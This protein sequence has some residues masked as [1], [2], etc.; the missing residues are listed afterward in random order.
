MACWDS[1][2]GRIVHAPPRPYPGHRGWLLIDCGCCAGI[3]WGGESP[4]ECD[5]CA[6]GG[7]QAQHKRSGVFALYPGGPFRG[8]EVPIK[9]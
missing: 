4:R 5:Q 8:R 2:A 9:G 7:F 6:G 3:R 1:A